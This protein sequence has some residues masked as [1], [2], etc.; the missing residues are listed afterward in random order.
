MGEET[1]T[2]QAN[3]DAIVNG[4][5]AR[6]AQ[7]HARPGDSLADFFAKLRALLDHDVDNARENGLDVAALEE[8]GALNIGLARQTLADIA[9]NLADTEAT[10][11]NRDNLLAGEAWPGRAELLKDYSEQ[12]NKLEL[13]RLGTAVFVQWTIAQV[14]V[15]QWEKMG[16]EYAI[17]RVVEPVI[18]GTDGQ[19]PEA[20]ETLRHIRQDPRKTDKFLAELRRAVDIKAAVDDHDARTTAALAGQGATMEGLAAKVAATCNEAREQ[21]PGYVTAGMAA[22]AL[23]RTFASAKLDPEATA[24]QL[25][26]RL[27]KAK[28]LDVITRDNRGTKAYSIPDVRDIVKA[29]CAASRKTGGMDPS[30]VSRFLSEL[31]DIP[32]RVRN[33]EET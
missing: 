19:D 28:G 16:A 12:L 21:L 1:K 10:R 15:C 9:H 33:P 5:M 17:E 31:T 25:R 27:R 13:E 22:R 6:S 20:K 23:C 7:F 30:D 26:Q 14:R 8:Q 4:I 18:R 29:H 11:A 2:T 3:I 24:T 32:G